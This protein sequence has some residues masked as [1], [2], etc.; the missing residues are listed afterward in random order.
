MLVLQP[1]HGIG[2]RG[3]GRCRLGPITNGARVEYVYTVA[4]RCQRSWP[5]DRLFVLIVLSGEHEPSRQASNLGAIETFVTVR[6]VGDR[7]HERV[8][9]FAGV[10]L[11]GFFVIVLVI[12]L[13]NVVLVFLFNAFGLVVVVIVAAIVA[14]VVVS[15]ILPAEHLS[16]CIIVVVFGGLRLWE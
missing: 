14:A 4:P 15:I 1:R 16:M 9:S 12:I 7:G 13:V 6:R 8:T 11:A 5:R 2:G 3:K 10:S